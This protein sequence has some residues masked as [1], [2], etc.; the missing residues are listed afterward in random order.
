MQVKSL[1]KKGCRSLKLSELHDHQ[2]QS[3]LFV[4]L[5][6]K[7]AWLLGC[8]RAYGAVIRKTTNKNTES[9][10]IK[11]FVSRFGLAVIRFGFKSCGLWTLPCDFVPHN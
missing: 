6:I 11:A 4:V 7:D 1:G 10:I 3:N 2:Q 5:F 9:E 8:C